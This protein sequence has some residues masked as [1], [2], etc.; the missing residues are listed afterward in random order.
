MICFVQADVEHRKD[1]SM[2]FDLVRYAPNMDFHL[3]V[4]L[5][6]IAV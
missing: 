1:M 6:E 5:E 2:M 3:L 4:H